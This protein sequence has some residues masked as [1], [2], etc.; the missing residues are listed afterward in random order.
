MEKNEETE[1][2]VVNHAGHKGESNTKHWII[3]GV[4]G[5][6]V[7]IIGGGLAWLYTGEIAGAKEKVFKSLPLPAAIVDM[8]FVSAQEALTRIE[9][10]KQLTEAQGAGG[11]IDTT[12]TYDQLIET[13]K[14]SS[15]VSSRNLSVSSEAIEEEYKNIVK[16]Y[17]GGDEEK[18]KTE[19]EATYKMSPEKFKAEVIKQE[20]EQSELALWYSKQQD[21]NKDAY[22]TAND[23]K[24]KLDSGQSFDE[25]AKVYTQDEATKDFAGDSGLI[26]YDDL[27]PEFRSELNDVKVGDIKLVPSRYGIHILKIL[28][29]NS[30]GENGA[31]Q[32]HLQQVFVKQT[33]Y[34]EWLENET[35]NVR[36][37]KLL[38]F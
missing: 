3:G 22:A 24:G 9:L 23:L 31:R 19:L 33:G 30:D 37:L 29:F 38:K 12:Q 7:I 5:L 4:I 35:N 15:I 21:L 14:L 27:L 16:Q 10:A 2:E 25:V 32:I 6:I 20:L 18:F 8:T 1:T 34:A 13:K 36:V 11:T 26:A 17:A 28:A